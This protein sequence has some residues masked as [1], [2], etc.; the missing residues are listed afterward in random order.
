MEWTTTQI[1]EHTYQVLTFAWTDSGNGL[2]S[3]GSHITM[4]DMDGEGFLVLWQVQCMV[5]QA[6]AASSWSSRGVVATANNVL[7]SGV[8]SVSNGDSIGSKSVEP[9]KGAATVWWWEEGHEIQGIELSHPS[10]VS[11]IQWRPSYGSREDTYTFRPVLLTSSNDGMVRLWLDMEG[12]SYSSFCFGESQER[13][14]KPIFSIGAVIEVNKCLSGVLGQNIFVSW[15]SETRTGGGDSDA[16]RHNS[17]TKGAKRGASAPC[18]W[19]VGVG[20][21]G[22]VVLWCIHSLDDILPT[23]SP[24]VTLWQKGDGLLAFP[25]T[26]MQSDIHNA[27]GRLMIKAVVQRPEGT[28]AVPPSS[29]DVFEALSGGLFRWSRLW[30]PVSAIGTGGGHVGSGKQPTGNKSPWG[31]SSQVLSLDGHHGVI[32]QVAMHPS[33]TVGLAASVDDQG[34][35]LLWDLRGWSSP[36]IRAMSSQT[37][38]WKLA[39]RISCSSGLSVSSGNLMSWAPISL[40]ESR[41]I[42]IVVDNSNIHCFLVSRSYFPGKVE[43]LV[44]S[45]L[46]YSLECPVLHAGQYLEGIGALSLSV[47]NSQD[48]TKDRRFIVIGAGG[49]GTILATWAVELKLILTTTSTI[50]ASEAKKGKGVEMESIQPL[51]ELGYSCYE[52]SLASQQ[53]CIYIRDSLIGSVELGH[54]E[55]VLSMAVVPGVTKGFISSQQEVYGKA[56]AYDFLTGCSDGSVKLYRAFHSESCSPQSVVARSGSFIWQCVGVVWADTGPVTKIASSAGGEKIASVGDGGNNKLVKT[57]ECDSYN[58]SG[59]FE[60][61][62]QIMLPQPIVSLS[63]LDTGMGGVLLGV[64]TKTDVNIYI[65]HR[66]CPEKRVPRSTTWDCLASFSTNADISNFLWG[67]QSSPIVTSNGH[68]RVCSRWVSSALRT[69]FI[70][71]VGR[72]MFDASN[73]NDHNAAQVYPTIGQESCTLLQAAEAFVYPLADY[74]PTALLWTLYKGKDP[75]FLHTIRA[76]FV[77]YCFLRSIHIFMNL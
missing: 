5:P 1:L 41:A 32:L 46:L 56:R 11:M 7:G 6:L 73:G 20:P 57:W 54:Q 40:S 59:G 13:K 74:H 66:I 28:L 42:L 65:Q 48:E 35:V 3:A 34:V 19:L 55:H 72:S 2:L 39:G 22:E 31:V 18:E 17:R 38:G 63:W 12:P 23:H 4:W 14:K 21:A 9:M 76:C 37:L 77:V 52:G 10:D 33:T 47:N 75:N 64:A 25:S 58:E 60:L 49:G 44:L 29:L 15:A 45:D 16:H 62:G 69:N 8:N 30:P 71:D 68:I 67:F 36:Q 26:T 24:Q 50:K 43:P 27:R 70:R 53:E 61:A 51:Q